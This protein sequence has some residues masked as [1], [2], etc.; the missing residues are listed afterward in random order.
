MQTVQDIK[1]ETLN[2]YGTVRQACQVILEAARANAE[3][4]FKYSRE[5][6]HTMSHEDAATL[7]D[8]AY[9]EFHY[10]E[11]DCISYLEQTRLWQNEEG[12]KDNDTIPR[13]INIQYWQKAV[14]DEL[15][16]YNAAKKVMDEHIK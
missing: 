16:N 9:M 11:V 1:P 4:I 15:K 13:D 5:N 7:H 12:V 14:K 10:N 3:V 8:K 2:T 6:L